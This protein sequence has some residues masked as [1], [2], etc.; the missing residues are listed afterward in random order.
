MDSLIKNMVV[1]L[2]ASGKKSRVIYVE[3]NIIVHI[4]LQGRRCSPVT[5]R[6]DDW[7][8]MLYDGSLEII[9]DPYISVPFNHALS[10]AMRSRKTRAWEA[11]GPLVRDIPGIFHPKIRHTRMTSR[12]LEVNCHVDSIRDWLTEYW[13]MGCTPSALFGKR[14]NCGAP[15]RSKISE[16]R[17]VAAADKCG[18]AEVKRGAPRSKTPGLGMNISEEDKKLIVAASN[19]FYKKNKK[20]TLMYAYHKMLR[21]FY[22]NSVSLNEKGKMEIVCRDLIPSYQQFLYWHRKVNPEF[23]LIQARRGKTFFEKTLRPLLGNSTFEAIGPGYRYQIDATIADVYLV[24]RIDRN[25]I[26]GR[27]VIYVVI[28]VWSR[29]IVGIYVGIENP[30][31]TIAMMAICNVAS[32]KVAYCKQYDIDIEADEWPDT[33][34]PSV[35]LGDRGEMLSKQ[36]DRLAEV[37]GIEVE[38]TPPYRADWKGIVERRFRLVPAKF[39]ADVPGYVQKDFGERT[40]PDYRLDS[41]L[42]VC[43]FTKIMIHC[44]LE[45]NAL[46]IAGYPLENSM[47]AEGV[48]AIPNRLWMWGIRNRMGTLARHSESRMLFALLPTASANITANGINFLSRNYYSRDVDDRGWFS[49]ARSEGRINVLISYHPHNLDTILLHDPMKQDQFTVCSLISTDSSDLNLYVE[50]VLAA[51]SKAAL[52][53]A[54]KHF[55]TMGTRL[56][57]QRAVEDIAKSAE[58]AKTTLAQSPKTKKERIGNIRSYRLIEKAL[59]R[60][61]C[62]SVGLVTLDHSAHQAEKKIL[63]STGT[64]LYARTPIFAENDDED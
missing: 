41:C 44:V 6:Y 32:N 38:N 53:L 12:A 43:D 55:D 22:P 59:D 62:S 3:R 9:E 30:S 14:K 8:A 28:D 17:T 15:G 10:E 37:L 50:E 36:A 13:Q 11:I 47:I 18:S 5:S 49:K 16:I 31:W 57:H 42:T 61:F 33:P 26:I 45:S 34:L 40:G 27:P 24:S 56:T 2:M 1:R 20:A 4:S 60:I 23:D 64:A 48:V 63:P 19:L 39:A 25:S 21:Q 35:I 46:P 7:L 54:S 52:T 51:K 29:L 58:A